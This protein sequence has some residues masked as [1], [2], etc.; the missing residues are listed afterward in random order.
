MNVKLDTKEKFTVITPNEAVI[1]ANMTA[2]FEEMLIG[3]IKKDIP[4]VILDMSCV[5][6]IDEAFGAM[7]VGIH[8]QFY[9]HNASFIVCSLQNNVISQL[10]SQDVLDIINITPTQSE[11]WDILQ[12]EE[13]ERELMRDADFEN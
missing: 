3:F 6:N 8:Q 4:H 13:I 1:P 11:A 12:M 5:E 9:D 10:K 7:L 2:G